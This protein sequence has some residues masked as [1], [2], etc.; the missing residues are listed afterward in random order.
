M[1]RET[2]AYKVTSRVRFIG[3]VTKSPTLNGARGIMELQLA[4]YKTDSTKTRDLN[5]EVI[6]GGASAKSKGV[7]RYAPTS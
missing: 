6:L 1:G 5:L 7:L 3:L 2:S 4:I